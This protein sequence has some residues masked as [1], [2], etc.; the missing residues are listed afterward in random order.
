MLARP[1]IPPRRTRMPLPLRTRLWLRWYRWRSARQVRAYHRAAGHS[2]SLC[3]ASTRQK[4][5]I[6]MGKAPEGPRLRPAGPAHQTPG[7]QRPPISEGKTDGTFWQEQRANT[8]ALDGNL[9]QA[10][11]A[12][13]PQ[14]S[15]GS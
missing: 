14:G 1:S 6:V 10:D 4:G 12:P 8:R 3:D 13:E 15:P 11:T 2:C 9:E 7:T 5:Q